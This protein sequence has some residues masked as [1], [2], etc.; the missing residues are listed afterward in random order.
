MSLFIGTIYLNSRESD[1]GL[2]LLR[3]HVK[4]IATPD[5]RGAAACQIGKYNVKVYG[6]LVS[7]VG[8][9][10]DILLAGEL[11]SNVFHALAVKNFDR[12]KTAQIDPT[13]NVLLM[14]ISG[15]VCMVGGVLGLRA[16]GGGGIVESLDFMMAIAGLIG[17]VIAL[18]RLILINRAGNWV[19]RP[20][21]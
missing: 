1:M 7:S 11:R 21:L 8:K 5:N 9:G 2:Q 10:D 6:D 12:D 18:R 16:V 20:E 17:M 3:G 14:G 4:D 13:N 19:S 15:F